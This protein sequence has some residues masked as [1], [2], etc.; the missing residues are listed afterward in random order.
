MCCVLFIYLTMNLQP[1]FLSL[2]LFWKL[3]G[4]TMRFCCLTSRLARS[5]LCIWMWLK[6][7]SVKNRL[8]VYSPWGGAK[9]CLWAAAE[10]CCGAA[11]GNTSIM[12]NGLNQLW[13][14]YRPSGNLDVTVAS[15]HLLCSPIKLKRDFVFTPDCHYCYCHSQTKVKSKDRSMQKT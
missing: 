8:G 6:S 7:A 1:F 9:S 13:L 3:M 14:S 11:A 15:P 4:C 2:L 10:M 12:E 5:A